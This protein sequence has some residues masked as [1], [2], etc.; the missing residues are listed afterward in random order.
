MYIYMHIYIDIDIDIDIDINIYH[1][2]YQCI[3]ITTS[4]NK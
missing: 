3:Y 4:Y 1:I 2:P